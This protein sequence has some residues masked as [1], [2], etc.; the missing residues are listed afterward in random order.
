[1]QKSKGASLARLIGLSLQ[2]SPEESRSKPLEQEPLL[3]A[4]IVIEDCM[5]LLLDI[6][7]IDR[8]CKNFFRG[9]EDEQVS[10]CVAVHARSSGKCHL[11]SQHLRLGSL[12]YRSLVKETKNLSLVVLILGFHVE[13]C[14]RYS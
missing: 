10:D 6:D 4:R 14:D 8:V 1:M 11:Q 12:S 7:D 3:A 5:C 9:R 13:L 2:R